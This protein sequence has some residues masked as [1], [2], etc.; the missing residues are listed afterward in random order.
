MHADE[1]VIL[2][3]AGMQQR[4]VTDR[5]IAADRGAQGPVADMDDSA[6]LDAGVV[7]DLDAG[8][9]APNQMPDMAPI[10]TSP[11]NV[12]L[13]AMKAEGSILGVKPLKGTIRPDMGRSSW[14]EKRA[15]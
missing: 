5:D 12:A 13:G 8:A 11:I 9:I 15:P 1:G 4:Q 3:L 2:N 10:S 6:I 7:T 14:V